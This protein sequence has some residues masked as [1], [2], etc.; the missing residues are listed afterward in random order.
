MN[1]QKELFLESMQLMDKPGWEILE[2]EDLLAFKSPAQVSFIE[3]VYGNVTARSYEKVKSFF[4]TKSYL[5]LLS[6]NQKDDLLI[7]LGFGTPHLTYEMGINL[8]EYKHSPISEPVQVREVRSSKDHSIWLD[9]AGK[10][11]NVS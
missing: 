11:L 9:V 6:E 4:R 2:E 5:W 10:W 8:S 3:F 7:Q 1:L